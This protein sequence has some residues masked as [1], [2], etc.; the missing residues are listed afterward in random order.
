VAGLLGGA[1]RWPPIRLSEPRNGRRVD[2]SAALPA[3]AQKPAPGVCHLTWAVANHRHA[4]GPAFEAAARRGL[5]DGRGRRLAKALA[6][7]LA[8]VEEHVAKDTGMRSEKTML[9]G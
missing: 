2:G 7:V 9:I 4:T 6:E 1:A 5:V 8:R 3:F